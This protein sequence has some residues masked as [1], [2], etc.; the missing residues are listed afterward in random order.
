MNKL[1]KRFHAL[2][3]VAFA[4][5]MLLAVGV[6]HSET[7]H[8]LHSSPQLIINA[9]QLN[10]A[11]DSTTGLS[12]TVDLSGGDLDK[13]SFQLNISSGAGS[14]TPTFDG[15]IQVSADGGSTWA[16]AGSFTQVTSTL[17]ATAVTKTNVATNPGTKLRIIPAISANTTF[18]S[19]KVYAMP[20]VD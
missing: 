12:S 2:S 14:T 10:S 7:F 5:A 8:K 3:V 18:Y 4:V 13:C 19:I 15:D 17:T 1:L 6:V 11:T 20:Q 9:V 16:T